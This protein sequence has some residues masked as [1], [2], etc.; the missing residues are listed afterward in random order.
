MGAAP[1]DTAQQAQ[2]VDIVVTMFLAYFARPAG[3]GQAART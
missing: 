2:L 1:I 3:A